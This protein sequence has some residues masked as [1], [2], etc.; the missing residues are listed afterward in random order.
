MSPKTKTLAG[1]AC[2]QAVLI[3]PSFT[4]RFSSLATSS[5]RRIRWMQNVHF[6]MMPLVRRETSGFSC[7]F[8]GLGHDGLNQVK[9]RTVYG[10]LFAQNLVPTHRL[11][12]CAFKPSGV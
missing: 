5:A 6:S 2:W 12:T 9:K 11:Y 3:S 10:Q 4:G 8:N 1:H 7:S